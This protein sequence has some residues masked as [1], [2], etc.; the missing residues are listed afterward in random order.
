MKKLNS[1]GFTHHLLIF[2]LLALV[3]GAAGFA[4]YRIY[5]NKKLDAQAERWTTLYSDGV[6]V[7]ACKQKP[8]YVPGT[9]GKVLSYKINILATPLVKLSNKDIWFF[10]VSE[11]NG[12]RYVDSAYKNSL[13]HSYRYVRHTQ[14]TTNKNASFTGDG[15]VWKN[16][17]PGSAKGAGAPAVKLQTIKDC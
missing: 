16:G 3:V 17:A 2:V 7:V 11:W 6:R 5:S 10:N 14:Y 8:V 9:K 15:I 1:K 13:K 12:D 4:G